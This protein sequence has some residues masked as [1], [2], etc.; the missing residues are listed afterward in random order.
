MFKE[1]FSIFK[2]I[3]QNKKLLLQFSFNDFKNNFFC[4]HLKLP[5]DIIL[6]YDI[7]A[8]LGKQATGCCY[9]LWIEAPG[10][11]GVGAVLWPLKPRA[12]KPVYRRK[13][14]CV[15]WRRDTRI[16]WF[17]MRDG[18]TAAEWYF[19]PQ[20]LIDCP[21]RCAAP[22]FLISLPDTFSVL[23]SAME[24]SYAVIFLQGYFV[25]CPFYRGGS[26]S[27]RYSCPLADEYYNW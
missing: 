26:C 20:P 23:L 11:F 24:I 16:H 18:E 13:W 27:A 19:V 4:F 2:N 8:G 3:F 14:S 15:R 10:L 7:A 5:H 6:D 17:T 22:P 21:S 12:W 25:Y 1:T 9:G